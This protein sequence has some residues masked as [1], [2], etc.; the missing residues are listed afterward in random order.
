MTLERGPFKPLKTFPEKITVLNPA[1]HRD[2]PK[3][4]KDILSN[5]KAHL[6]AREIKLCLPAAK[7]DQIIEARIK[8]KIFLLQ[9][10]L[11]CGK[12]CNGCPHGPYWYGFYKTHGQLISFYVGKTLPPRFREATK[13][14]IASGAPRP[15]SKSLVEAPPPPSSTNPSPVQNADQ[16]SEVH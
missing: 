14:H 1:F 12:G 8:G 2:A 11:P 15:S 6:L 5:L 7:L 13:I 9:R 16:E 3:Y 10:K 4:I